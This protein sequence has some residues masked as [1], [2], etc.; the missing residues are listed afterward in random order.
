MVNDRH[1]VSAGRRRVLVDDEYMRCD[2][3]D[4]SF[5]TPSQSAALELRVREQVAHDE[6]L[7]SGPEIRAIRK[8]LRF[9]DIEFEALLGVG[10]KS[11]SRWEN[12]HVRPNVATDR[13]IRLIAADRKNAQILAAINGVVLP[14]SCFVPEGIL[15]GIP[16]GIWAIDGLDSR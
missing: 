12:G 6:N 15:A 2:P 10:A 8:A 3:C 5:Y 1:E 7:L 13:L 11:C 4:E 16:S 9:S 14:D